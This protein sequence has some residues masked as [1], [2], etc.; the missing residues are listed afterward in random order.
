ML[1]LQNERTIERTNERTLSELRFVDGW[2]VGARLVGC[3][4][5]WLV[6]WLVGLLVGKVVDRIC[7]AAAVP[8]AL[9]DIIAFEAGVKRTLTVDRGLMKL[10]ACHSH[11]TPSV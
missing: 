2:V 6:A 11:R 7:R 4:V 3:L 5:G 9:V 8:P 1:L 10:G